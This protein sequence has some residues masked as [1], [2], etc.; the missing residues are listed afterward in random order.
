MH[1]GTMSLVLQ[2][3]PLQQE[4]DIRIKTLPKAPSKLALWTFWAK[5][6]FEMNERSLQRNLKH[7]KS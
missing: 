7:K 4:K 2:M 6:V 1:Q 3:L 5:F